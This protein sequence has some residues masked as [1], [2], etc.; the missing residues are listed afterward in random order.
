MTDT[1]N[2]ATRP[3][4]HGPTSGCTT[5]QHAILGHWAKATNVGTFICRPTADGAPSVHGSGRA[6]D[7]GPGADPCAEIA[8]WL[9]ENH[10]VLGVQLVIWNHK[11]WNVSR[12]A[13][14][15]RP[16][17][18]DVPGSKKDHHTGHVHWEINNDAARRLTPGIIDAVLPHPAPPDPQPAPIPQPEP[19][20][21]PDMDFFILNDNNDATADQWHWWPEL[22]GAKGTKA[23]IP[24]TT[25]LAKAKASKRFCGELEFD[26]PDLDAIPNLRA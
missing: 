20:A 5:L 3:C 24:G 12:S 9:V 16:Y 13:E 10:T 22:G 19:E 1:Y 17:G 11:I 14:G 4:A 25:G 2:P 15:W 23:I 8:A 6:G 7:D 26:R 21:L 18:C